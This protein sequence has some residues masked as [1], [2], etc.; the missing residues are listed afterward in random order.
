[1]AIEEKVT[2]TASVNDEAMGTVALDST[3]GKYFSGTQVTVTVTAN[4]GYVLKSITVGDEEVTEGWTTGGN[5]YTYTFTVSASNTAVVAT[6]EELQVW[7]SATLTLNGVAENTE[8]KLF[9]GLD[10]ITATADANGVVTFTD[11]NK[12]S[13]KVYTVTVGNIV[14][15]VDFTTES[16]IRK[17]IAT[18]NVDDFKAK[19]NYNEGAKV[20]DMGG[21]KNS[22]D[23]VVTFNLKTNSTAA[24]WQQRWSLLL[25][26]GDGS[27][28][29]GI[30]CIGMNNNVLTV[31]GAT[32]ASP[33]DANQVFKGDDK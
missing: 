26:N 13:K 3:D 22:T 8:V 18:V 11:N 29:T 5:V 9:D 32:G 1:M 27:T 6:F 25:I 23:Y 20:I 14:F 2:V 24:G 12:I 7:E 30:G 17:T 16:S 33:D 28:T 4:A 10:T 19:D 21:A 31:W 15:N